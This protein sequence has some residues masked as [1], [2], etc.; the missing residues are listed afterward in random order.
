MFV[1]QST[2]KEG[3]ESEQKLS[4][5]AIAVGAGLLVLVSVGLG[6][7]IMRRSKV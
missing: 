2:A 6:A 5:A 7:G 1:V 3:K 4:P